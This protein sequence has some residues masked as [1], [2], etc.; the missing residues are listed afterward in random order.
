MT[1]G[2]FFVIALKKKKQ[3]ERKTRVRI[4]TNSHGRKRKK[5]KK[6]C[7]TYVRGDKEQKRKTYAYS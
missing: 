1:S 4:S 6:R 7:P 5:G 3:K 2:I